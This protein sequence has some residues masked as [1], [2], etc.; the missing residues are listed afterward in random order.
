[1]RTRWSSGSLLNTSPAQ[2]PCPERGHSISGVPA[3]WEVLPAPPL[4]PLSMVGGGWR[5]QSC[6]LSWLGEA[7]QLGELWGRPVMEYV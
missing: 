3:G 7:G 2:C 4:C 1:M 5:A 6:R